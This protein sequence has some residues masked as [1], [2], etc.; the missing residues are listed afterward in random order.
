[1]AELLQT[2]APAPTVK[3]AMNILRLKRQVDPFMSSLL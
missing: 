2:A 3:A 1:M